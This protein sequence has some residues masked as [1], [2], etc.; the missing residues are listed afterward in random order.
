MSLENLI[1]V[2][3]TAPQTIYA[4]GGIEFTSVILQKSLNANETSPCNLVKTLKK[5]KEPPSQNWSNIQVKGNATLLDPNSVLYRIFEKA[6]TINSKNI[7]Q[8]PVE[9]SRH[10]KAE[11]VFTA[12]LVNGINITEMMEDAVLI[13]PNEEQVKI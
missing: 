4:P 3:N 8:A 7:I 1:D 11:N 13:D 10:V 9:F 2:S 5:I 6:V 12:G